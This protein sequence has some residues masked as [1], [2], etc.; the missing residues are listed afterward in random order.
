[1]QKRSVAAGRRP[2]GTDGSDF[3]YRMVVDSRYTKV[4]RGK[5]RLGG[6]LVAQTASQII[7]TVLVFLSALP[8]KK[9]EAVPAVSLSLGFISLVIGELGRRRSSK[10][11]LRL[12]NIFSSVATALSVV[13]IFRSNLHLKVSNLQSFTDLLIYD[14]LVLVRTVI[15]VCLQI[16]AL[17]TSITLVH[18]MSPQTVS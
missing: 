6:L 9:I 7:W 3:S 13:C 8:E 5:S 12:Y 11:L 4:A 16:F 2:S 15:G 10:R 1:M 18:N 17:S 14:L